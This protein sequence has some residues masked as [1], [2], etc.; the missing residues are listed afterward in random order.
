ML[1]RAQ[2]S[3]LRPIQLPDHAHI[4]MVI[5]R[6]PKLF[7]AMIGA[8]LKTG[9]R[10]DELAQSDRQHFDRERKQLTVVGKRNKL[11]VI[12]LVDN[13]DDF[14][15]GIFAALPASL[16]TKALFWH[17]HEAGPRSNGQRPAQRYRQVSSNFGP[18]VE[19]VAKQAQNQ[20][21]EFRSFTSTIYVIGQ[22]R[23]AQKWPFYLRFTATARPHLDQDD[24]MYLAYITPEEAQRAML[25]RVQS[26]SN[27]GNR[28]SVRTTS[29]SK[30]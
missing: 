17:R 2:R 25:G 26:G 4:Q 10:L 11:R 12:D 14:G 24:Q 16:E 6:A 5:D 7:A 27:S 22:R 13:G 8:A 9:A 21:Q 28:P 20:D 3:P 30:L 18:I 15:F 23:L 29:E 19:A 1:W